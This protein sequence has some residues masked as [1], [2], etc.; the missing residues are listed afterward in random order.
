[1]KPA[2]DGIRL[3]G[4]V[5]HRKAGPVVPDRRMPRT[6]QMLMAAIALSWHSLTPAQAADKSA[7]CQA[8]RHAPAGLKVDTAPTR[9]F[10]RSVEPAND[11]APRLVRA[12][13]DL[14]MKAL[15]AP[16]QI[17]RWIKEK[18]AQRAAASSD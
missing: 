13:G 4:V 3:F 15:A 17:A 18:S 9:L 10:E 11:R 16:G 2:R 5:T 14:A 1:L 6:V 12:T 8:P 7:D